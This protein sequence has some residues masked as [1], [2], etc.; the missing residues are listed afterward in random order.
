[1]LPFPITLTVFARPIIEA[2]LYGALAAL[3]FTI[4]PLARAENIR[5]QFCF[6]TAEDRRA[7]T[8]PIYVIITLGLTAILLASA[9]YFTGSIA[10]TLWTAVGVIGALAIL[11]IAAVAIR[12]LAHRLQS[13]SKGRSTL[14]WALSAIGG[15]SEGATAVILS[16]GLGLSVL[17]SIGQI[18]GNLRQAIKQDLPGVAPSYFFV[19]IQ[20]SQMPEFR[21]I[22][23]A[24]ENVSDFEEAQCC[25]G[26]F[27]RSMTNRR[28]GRRRPLGDPR[29]SWS[30]ICRSTWRRYR[31]NRV[32][33]GLRITQARPKSALPLKK[34]LKWA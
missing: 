6:A 3:I 16:I 15:T 19:D 32:H 2:T 30:D 5:R 26:S 24:D 31:N 28:R 29:G 22:L 7:A 33:G 25:A 21:E 1:M 8:S 4:W 20:K 23:N 34:G 11:S 13:W 14:R 10:L 27:R 9:C 12:K 18:D 17:A